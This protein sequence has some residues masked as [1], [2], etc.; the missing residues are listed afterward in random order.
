MFQQPTQ[1]REQ[2]K[3][4]NVVRETNTPSVAYASVQ[5]CTG[6]DTEP[7]N[8]PIPNKSSTHSAKFENKS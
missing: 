1:C 8:Q 3:A 7:T 2:D 6:R 4:A 5:E